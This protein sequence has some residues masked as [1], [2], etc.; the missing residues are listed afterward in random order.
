MSAQHGRPDLH[1]QVLGLRDKSKYLHFVIMDNLKNH[2][3]IDLF[4]LVFPVDPC[5]LGRAQAKTTGLS[6]R[7]IDVTR[8]VRGLLT[9]KIMRLPKAQYPQQSSLLP[10]PIHYLR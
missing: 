8:H 4:L 2:M 10:F 9:V 6:L 7:V 1:Q 5:M 3:S